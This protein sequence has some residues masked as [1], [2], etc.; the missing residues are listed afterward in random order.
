M[1]HSDFKIP[2]EC[3]RYEY[4]DGGGPWFL[5]NGL[6]RNPED[7][8]AFEEGSDVLY[9]CDTIENL[10][11]YMKFH[12]IDTSNMHLVHYYDIEVVSYRKG[13][14][15]VAFKIKERI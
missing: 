2:K 14:G 1:A 9:G 10:N 15:H 6:P 7:I 13:T 12:N 8:P 4:A 3:W 11:D 5:P